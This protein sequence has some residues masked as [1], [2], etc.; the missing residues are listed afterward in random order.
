MGLDELQPSN[1]LQVKA[2]VTGAF[3]EF[4]KVEQV[5]EEYIR[6]CIEWEESGKCFVTVMDTLGKYLA[7]S[8]GSKG[9]QLARNTTMQILLESRLLKMRKT[10]DSFCLKRDGGQY[11]NKAIPCLKSYL[12][13]MLVYLYS[14]ACC[15]TDYQDLLCYV[16]FGTVLAKQNVSVDS[17]GV[18]FLRL[19]WMKTSE[20]Q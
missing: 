5:K 19:I 1:T 14:S 18:R 11:V 10:L 8:I 20:K 17:G 13:R 9:K 2:M 3:K 6:E 16:C 7:F 12:K 4:L 15:E